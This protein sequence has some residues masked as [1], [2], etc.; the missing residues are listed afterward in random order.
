MKVLESALQNI[1][2]LV[3]SIRVRRSEKEAVLQDEVP[4][5]ADNA[6]DHLVVIEVHSNPQ[7]RGNRSVLV[8][9]KRLVVKIAIEGLDEEHRLG[10]LRRNLLHRVRIQQRQT[11]GVQG[12]L[13]IISKKLLD[14]AKL[15]DLC[16]S[17]NRP[18]FKPDDDLIGPVRNRSVLR[19]YE[20]RFGGLRSYCLILYSS[21]L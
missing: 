5:I 3:I 17:A 21:A 13:R 1:D 12:I 16:Q 14:R 7:S 15:I 20:A 9:V 10:V 19:S 4:S 11:D 8:E 2:Q 18:I 6:F